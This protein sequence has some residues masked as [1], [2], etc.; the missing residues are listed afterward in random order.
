[1]EP[2]F[3]RLEALEIPPEALGDTEKKPDPQGN[4]LKERIIRRAQELRL[5]WQEMEFPEDQPDSR[6]RRDGPRNDGARKNRKEDSDD[7]RAQ[8]NENKGPRSQQ[9]GLF[10]FATQGTVKE[11]Q[12]EPEHAWIAAKG[13]TALRKLHRWA[14]ESGNLEKSEVS[15]IYWVALDLD[16]KKP[17][18]DAN[19]RRVKRL[20]EKAVRKGFIEK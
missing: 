19:A 7:E 11:S 1:M 6:R 20:W 2:I 16:K 14:K 10:G 12:N 8:Q 9:Q 13:S 17:L 4:S 18:S 15:L 5:K 3:S